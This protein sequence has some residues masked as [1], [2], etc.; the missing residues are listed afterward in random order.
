MMN[1][2]M[3][4]W[5]NNWQKDIDAARKI[6]GGIIDLAEHQLDKIWYNEITFHTEV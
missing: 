1:Q 5:R 3:N 2:M 4:R 6:P